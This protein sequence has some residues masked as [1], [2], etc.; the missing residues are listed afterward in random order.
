MPPRDLASLQDIIIAA[1]LITSFIVGL[2]RETFG[3]N[4]LIQ[5]AVVRQIEIIGEATK[6]LSEEMRQQHTDIPW[7]QM[8]GMRDILIHA[9][10]SVDPDE[11]WNAASRDLPRICQQIQAIVADFQAPS[12]NDPSK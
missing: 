5:S 2:K 8:A 6:R 7:K 10:D 4:L 12:W 11:V 1:E 9:Y 3:E